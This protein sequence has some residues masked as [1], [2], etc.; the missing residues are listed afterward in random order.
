VRLVTNESQVSRDG[1]HAKLVKLGYQGIDVDHVSAPGPIM[2]DLIKEQGLKPHFL[3]HP[4]V[5]ATRM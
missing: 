1:S 4:G 2:A 5:M 3:I